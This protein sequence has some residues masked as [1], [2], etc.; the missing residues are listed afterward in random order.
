MSRSAS[1]PSRQTSAWISSPERPPAVDRAV[2]AELLDRLDGPVERDPGHHLGVGEVPP[3]AAHLPDALVRL[4][5]RSTPGTRAGPAARSPGRRRSA[6]GRCGG[7]WCRASMHLAVDV[8]LELA[9]RPR[10]RSAPART[11]RSRAA[12]RSSSS[13]SRRSPAEAVHDLHLRA[14]WPATARSSHSRHARGLLAVAGAAAGPE[15]EGGVAQPAVAVVPVADAAELLGQR[16]GRGGDDAAGRG[17]GQRLEGDQRAD[18]RVR[19]SRPGSRC[20]AR[21]TRRH[22]A[23]VSPRACDG[24]DAGGAG[25]VR[26][27][28]GRA[29]TATRSPSAT[30]KSARL[31]QFSPRTGT[32]VRSQTESGPAIARSAA[33]D[34][35]DPGHDRAVVEADDQLHPHRHPAADPLDDPDHVRVPARAAA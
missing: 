5:P 15:G 8:E 3:R 23:S 26:G 7:A 1:K 27:M 22:Q 9:A 34:V 4:A 19:A 11:P 25:L 29:R 21:P 33:L 35:P 31:V 28:P 14:G 13:V 6:P 24:V 16:G 32:G 10:C 2:E 17:V 12:S 20:T 18:H 30:V